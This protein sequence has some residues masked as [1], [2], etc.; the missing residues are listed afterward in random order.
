MT[1]YAEL[2]TKISTQT[3]PKTAIQQF[4]KLYQQN[5]VQQ[6]NI[7]QG[8]RIPG[9]NPGHI[10]VEH[11]VLNI[12]GRANAMSPTSILLPQNLEKYKN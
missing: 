8:W 12:D 5:F 7:P 11:G 10:F 3:Q 4:K 9:N 1:S 6:N 2:A